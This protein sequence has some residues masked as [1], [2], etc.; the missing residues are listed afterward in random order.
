MAREISR[1]AFLAGA[2]GTVAASALLGGCRAPGPAPHA[3]PATSGTPSPPTVSGPKDWNA[4]ASAIE[5]QV[6]LPSN[7]EYAAAKSVFNSRFDN[8]TPAAVV[9]VKSSD[10]VKKA[11]EF[12]ARNHVKVCA[13]SGGH[14]YIGASAADAAMV[15]D[16]RQ[17]P[18]AISYDDHGLA[19]VPAAAQLDSVQTALAEHGQ[20]IPSGSCPTV[21][22]SGLTLGGGLGSDARRSGLTCDAL[23]SASVVLPGG[24]A[25]TASADDHPDA[26]WALRGG[27]GGT[28]GVVTSLTF[29]T[30]P[31]VDRDVVTLVFPEGATSEVI[32]GWY[33][34]LHTADRA[35]W[36]M[37]NITVGSGSGGCTV[38]L[39]TPAGTGSST[40]G[41][42]STAIGV[43]PVS[44]SSRTLDRMDFVHYFEG[45]SQAT[46]PRAFVAGSDIVGEMSSA[47]AE[48]IVAATA[49]WP[50]D[51]GASTTVLESLSGAV[52]D[53][54]S[55]DTAFP[56][57][58]HAASIQWYTEPASP[59]A[60]DS[61]NEWLASAH[62]ALQPHS[63][64]GYVNYLEPDTPAS[65]Y[66]GENQGRLAAVR[67]TYDPTGLMYSGL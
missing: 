65:R 55:G 20:S 22:I 30:F 50:H 29:R 15:I 32:F 57:R 9:A 63:A 28:I 37:V 13:R 48:S 27:G 3:P 35:I 21:G 19:T 23:V 17:L 12:A 5:G 52:N 34:W 40:A 41:D 26:F 10:D 7:A 64:G 11:M 44:N 39:A 58:R 36:G 25:I 6:I 61:A 1:Q 45:G 56:W 18:C 43:Q 62:A 38:V 8:S 46:Q 31:T 49:A 66:F 60:T 42:L 54:D 67:Q 4:L 53:V 47:A 16:L 59:S 24:E 33:E 2:L 14:S 51:A